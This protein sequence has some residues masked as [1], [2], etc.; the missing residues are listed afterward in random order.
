M[1]SNTHP[2][3]LKSLTMLDEAT[4]EIIFHD[5]LNIDFDGINPTCSKSVNNRTIYQQFELFDLKDY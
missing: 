1:H 5:A 3:I 4:I 2:S